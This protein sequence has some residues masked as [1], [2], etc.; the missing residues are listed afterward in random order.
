MIGCGNVFVLTTCQ[1][2]LGAEVVDFLKYA[3]I[4]MRFAAPVLAIVLI[5]KDIITAAASGK[6]DDMKKAQKNMIKRLIILVVIM[7]LPT[8]I[9]IILGLISSAS[10]GANVYTRCGVG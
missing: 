6:E 3:F 8:I 9:D 4:G 5:A 1:D 2:L 7:F 10:S